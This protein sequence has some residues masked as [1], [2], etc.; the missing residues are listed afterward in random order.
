VVA[1]FEEP[2]GLFV[3]LVERDLLVGPLGVRLLGVLEDELRGRLVLG[4]R[5]G[6]VVE[7]VADVVVVD[8]LEVD[9]AVELPIVDRLR[10]AVRGQFLYLRGEIAEDLPVGLRLAQRLDRRRERVHV[11]VHVR[12]R[13][14]VSVVARRRQDDIAVERRRVHPEVDVDDQIELRP[15]LLFDRDVPLGLIEV[16]PAPDEHDSGSGRPLSSRSLGYSGIHPLSID[17]RIFAAV[18]GSVFSMIPAW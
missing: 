18:S 4:Q 2:F 15:Q 3:D 12:L 6:L 5:T 9:L 1:G 11:G 17:S 8:R 10:T 7:P 16:V 13:G 14:R